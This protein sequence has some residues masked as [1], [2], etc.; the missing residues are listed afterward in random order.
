M[1]LSI[2]SASVGNKMWNLLREGKTCLLLY[3]DNLKSLIWYTI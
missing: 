3:R 2:F 1:C